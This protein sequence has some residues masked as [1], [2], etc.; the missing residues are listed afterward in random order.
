MCFADLL[1]FWL[2]DRKSGLSTVAKGPIEAFEARLRELK[3]RV[4]RPV[5]GTSQR[6]AREGKLGP[7]G[8]W[9]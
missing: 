5:V 6:P 9:L 7:G 2:V 8:R 3:L 4:G 1:I